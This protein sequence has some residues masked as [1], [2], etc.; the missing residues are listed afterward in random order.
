MSDN[1]TTND[2]SID[3]LTSGEIAKELA[4]IDEK[5]DTL[6]ADDFS[7]RVTLHQRHEDLRARAAQLAEDADDQRSTQDL[8]VEVQSL[9][10]RLGRIQDELIDVPEQTGEGNIPGPDS[11]HR[12]A[13]GL[14]RD[15]ADAQDAPQMVARINKLQRIISSRDAEST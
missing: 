2:G 5:L 7:E 12:S 13:A 11:V 6:P 10:Q 1:D 9:Q 15:M 8:Q 14:N 4:A 3:N